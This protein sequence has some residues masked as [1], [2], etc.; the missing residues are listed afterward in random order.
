MGTGLDWWTGP[1]GLGL[2]KEMH[3]C[4][5]Q[6]RKKEED[7]FC[8]HHQAVFCMSDFWET[9]HFSPKLGEARMALQEFGG[10]D[11]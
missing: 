6:Q 8:M 11:L 9:D 5:P 4:A 1:R 3:S 10:H 7:G 2:E